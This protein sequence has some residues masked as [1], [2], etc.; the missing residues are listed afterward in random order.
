MPSNLGQLLHKIASLA[1]GGSSLRPL[2]H[3]LRRLKIGKSVW[4]SQVV[5]LDEL[6]PEGILIGA[7]CAVCL[8]TA[9][10]VPHTS[11]VEHVSRNL[12]G[13]TAPEHCGL[14]AGNEGDGI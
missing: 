8:R 6:L 11:V 10:L 7:I 2:L 9:N 1:P 14:S 5:Y 13:T 12:N 3:R 4:V